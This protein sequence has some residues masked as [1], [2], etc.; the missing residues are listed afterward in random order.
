MHV[1]RIV[2]IWAGFKLCCSSSCD[3]RI[4]ALHLH[5][6]LHHPDP[7]RNDSCNGRLGSECGID[8]VVFLALTDL[9]GIL[10]K[11]PCL[12]VYC[13]GWHG[14]SGVHGVAR[15][16]DDYIA[17]HVCWNETAPCAGPIFCIPCSCTRDHE[18]PGVLWPQWQCMHIF[19]IVL[20]CCRAYNMANVA[21]MQILLGLCPL[22]VLSP[23]WA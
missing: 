19:W 11:S 23:D 8:L 20:W 4:S 9:V 14:S 6:W 1:R 3:I 13:L 5:D 18:L 15:Y 10:L 17:A 21:V 7:S 16:W 22:A 2:L 12:D